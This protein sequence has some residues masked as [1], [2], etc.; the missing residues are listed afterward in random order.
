ME[1]YTI[2]YTM[3]GCPHCEHIKN[4]L[5]ENN[6]D[7]IGRDI[8]DHESEYE[9]FKKRT[10]SD[11]VPAMLI[12]EKEGEKYEPYFYVPEQHYNE[13][14]EAVEIIKKHNFKVM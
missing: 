13:I 6:I 4:V 5:T 10:G 3:K 12:I 8:D 1:V 9:D 14:H 2:I 11:F 7:F